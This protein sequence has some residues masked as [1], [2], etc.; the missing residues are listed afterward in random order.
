MQDG[1]KTFKD[2]EAHVYLFVFVINIF[3]EF[4]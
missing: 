2:T 4:R 1:M 3:D